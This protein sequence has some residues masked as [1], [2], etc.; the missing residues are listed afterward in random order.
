[1]YT[2]ILCCYARVVSYYY[3]SLLLKYKIDL[4][5][6][7]SIVSFIPVSDRLH[8]YERYNT[9]TEFCVYMEMLT[10]RNRIV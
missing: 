7:Y 4:C 5:L 2:N 8:Y 6:L 10:A 9:I 1:M 3:I